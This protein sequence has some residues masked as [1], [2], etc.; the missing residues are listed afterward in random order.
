MDFILIGYV[1]IM[2]LGTLWVLY[3][4]VMFVRTQRDRDRRWAGEISEAE[5]A[6]FIEQFRRS[7][8]AKDV[9]Q[10]RH[11]KSA[12]VSENS[13]TEVVPTSTATAGRPPDRE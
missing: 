8:E 7:N 11:G 13:A 3:K 4:V 2:T 10:S 12:A 1:G 5:F 6:A 9:E